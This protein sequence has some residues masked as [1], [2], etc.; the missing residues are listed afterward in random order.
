MVYLTK[1]F[2]Y[3]FQNNKIKTIYVPKKQIIKIYFQTLSDDE[4]NLD[5]VMDS[6]CSIM[7]DSKDRIKNV[8]KGVDRIAMNISV[9]ILILLLILV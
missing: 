1:S 7:M 3:I 6:K 5:F 8:V 9:S 2:R 4:E